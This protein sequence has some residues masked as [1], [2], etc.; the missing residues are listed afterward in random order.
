MQYG[1]ILLEYI[2][3]LQIKA[4]VLRA[5]HITMARLSRC[6]VRHD[7]AQPMCV[8]DVLLEDGEGKLTIFDAIENWS[9]WR[10][11]NIWTHIKTTVALKGHGWKIKIFW[12]KN[13][14]RVHKLISRALNLLIGFFYLSSGTHNLFF[15]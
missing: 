8:I 3:D 7:N 4:D 14:F 12:N 10:L 1:Y 2:I 6:H 15:D 13:I 11:R 5:G 9:T